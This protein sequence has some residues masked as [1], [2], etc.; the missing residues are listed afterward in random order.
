MASLLVFVL[1][2]LGTFRFT[3][4]ESSPSQDFNCSDVIDC[5]V[6][7]PPSF[8][9]LPSLSEI[10]EKLSNCPETT[11][12]RL[13]HHSYY[14]RDSMDEDPVNFKIHTGDRLPQLRELSLDGYDF[15]DF[16]LFREPPDPDHGQSPAMK[17][18][19]LETTEAS[20][21]PSSQAIYIPGT[22]LDVWKDAMDWTALHELKLSNIDNI[23][24]YKMKGNLPLVKSLTVQNNKGRS[25]VSDYMTD[26]ITALNPL[27]KLSAFGYTGSVDWSQ[28]FDRHGSTLEA[29]EIQE[30]NAHKSED[31]RPILST[32]QI[33]EISRKCPRLREFSVNLNM[34]T[35]LS[36]DYFDALASL[37]NLTSLTIRLRNNPE[38]HYQRIQN[39]H[40]DDDDITPLDYG[41]EGES[42]PPYINDQTVLKMF[43]ELRLRKQ[44]TELTQL[45]AQVGNHDIHYG[46]ANPS[47]NWA[48]DYSTRTSK[49][50]CGVLNEDGSRKIEGEAWC[51]CWGVGACH[52]DRWY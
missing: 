24:F 3:S 33:E 41:I 46:G 39:Y 13:K 32:T 51:H 31:T 16:R 11:S 10:Y 36:S 23:F 8:G 44:G 40:F 14:H 15:G 30:W 38:P 20:Y 5:G 25:N 19:A 35:E 21:L 49:H 12:L 42:E 4:A 9:R 17:P 1:L 48:I 6:D 50:V 34:K 22:N 47:L 43:Q 18:M 26:F 2:V 27:Q 29:L 45:E 7:T 52:E 28:V 37:K